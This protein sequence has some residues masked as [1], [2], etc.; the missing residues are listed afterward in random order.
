MNSGALFGS[1][2]WAAVACKDGY[3]I[4]SDHTETVIIVIIY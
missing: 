1:L 3:A 4:P 2:S